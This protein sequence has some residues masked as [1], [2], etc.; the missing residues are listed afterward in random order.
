VKIWNRNEI[1]SVL[2]QHSENIYDV[3]DYMDKKSEDAPENCELGE[4]IY[5]RLSW[6]YR[7]K[8]LSAIPAKLTVTELKR[9]LDESLADEAEST[10]YNRPLMK[11]PLFLQE[12]KGL[13]PAEKGTALHFVMQHLDL[14]QVTSKEALERQIEAMVAA[15]MLTALQAE[16]VPVNRILSFF[17]SEIGMQMLNSRKVYREIP[18]NMEIGIT[19]L[20]RDISHELRNE[21]FLVQG[22]IDCFFEHE[23]GVVLL[24]YKTDFL[25]A[26]EEEA[27]KE[28][29]RPQI[30]YYAMALERMKGVKV[31]RKVIYLFSTGQILN[32]D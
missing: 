31:I 12:I 16:A 9:R 2:E 22:V 11:K 28:R 27:L 25:K 17:S 6:S 15:N 18:F 32:F 13:S 21:A 1:P 14:R 8:G 3:T 26:G 7:F 10:G 29:Y 4:S 19:E 20:Y 24:D 23:D 30:Q 5:D